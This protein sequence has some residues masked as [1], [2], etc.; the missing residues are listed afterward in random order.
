MFC[1]YCGAEVKDSAKFC[2]KCGSN[3]ERKIIEVK[4]MNAA[5]DIPNTPPPYQAPQP[6]QQPPQQP[7]A[8]NI[9][10]Q[11]PR[12]YIPP[13]PPNHPP[14]S[15]GNLKGPGGLN[16][17]IIILIIALVAGLC[18]NIFQ[19]INGTHVLSD[20]SAKLS[21]YKTPDASL[22]VETA[23]W[24]AVPLNQLIIVF[25]DDVGKSEAKKTI[26]QLGGVIVGELETINLYQIETEIG[27]EAELLGLVDTALSMNGVET[28]FPNVE[29]S[30]KDAEGNHC[31]PLRDP[32]YSDPANSAHYKAI[33]MENAWRIIKSSG[34]KLNSVT[35]GVLDDSIYSGS[36]EYNG[37]VKLSGDKTDQPKTNAYNDIV[38]GGLNHGTMVTNVIAADDG[39]DGMVGIAAVL[40]DRLSVNVK[41]LYD[42]K[43]DELTAVDENDIT[44]IGLTYNGKDYAY[45]M[46]AL[47]YL[48]QQV[49]S[50]VTVI[51]CSYGPDLP[52]DKYQLISKAYEKFFKEI[53]KTHPG[54][55]FVAAAG[56][57]GQDPISKG[58]LNGSNYFPAGMKLPNVITVGAL[59]NDGTRAAFSNYAASEDAEVTLSAPGVE[60][61]LGTDENGQPIKASGTSF[62]AP[63]VSAAI[64]IIQSISPGMDAAQIKDLL[65][66][67]AAS[68]VTTESGSTPIPEGL[69]KG[70]LRVDEAVLKAIN[71]E[72]EKEGQPPFTMQ[73]LLDRSSVNLFAETG[74]REYTLRASVPDAESASVS[75]KLEVKGKCSIDGDT[76]QSVQVGEEAVWDLSIEDDSVFVRV[77]RTDTEGCAFMTL[78]IYESVSGIYD[79]K[80]SWDGS[81]MNGEGPEPLTDWRARVDQTDASMTITFLNKS[82]TVLTGS[83]D[84]ITGVFVGMD[85]NPPADP[86]ATTWWTQ[87]YTTITFDFDSMPMTAKG[88][89][90]WN[91]EEQTENHLF[92]W[93]KVDFEM[94]KVEELP[95]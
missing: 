58:G 33:G 11:P 36:N 55:V 71:N 81:M 67:T 56:N 95:S 82:G 87:D 83:Y 5:G 42:G 24:G 76:V 91:W 49:E 84:E 27:S 62:A 22:V 60:M 38:K 4:K 47:V 45:T 30:N 34:V 46:K 29:I 3:V 68:S 85:N 73:E 89:L 94:V 37:K 40:G 31:T 86:F 9:P 13:Q 41:N 14:A 44:Q 8:Q 77:V 52:R 61:L 32:V 75:L 93:T 92:D 12:Q 26:E 59:N 51:N 70:I 50:G 79:V 23:E 69:G 43:K 74:F 53:Y 78:K 17:L 1:K 35:A 90:T 20:G 65:V 25:E 80:G 10:Q 7:V 54:V 48:K 2:P 16:V 66:E 21:N 64:A 63:Q 28:A 19:F 18:V 39:N 88:T 6:Q 57:E 15:G 72:R